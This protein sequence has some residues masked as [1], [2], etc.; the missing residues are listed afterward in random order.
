MLHDCRVDR[1]MTRAQGTLQL[2]TEF[3]D[4]RCHPVMEHI[5]VTSDIQGRVCLRDT[6]MTFGPLERRTEGG[7]VQQVSRGLLLSCYSPRHLDTFVI[8][9]T[10]NFPSH[11]RPISAIPNLVALHSIMKV[12][13][14]LICWP[15]PL[16][17]FL[18]G[19]KLAVTM[20]VGIFALLNRRLDAIVI[21]ALPANYLCSLRSKS[22]CHMQRNDSSRWHTCST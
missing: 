13:L 7:V 9:T 11:L 16:R 15:L 21:A 22:Y 17:V 1:T 8:S 18:Q 14:F 19:S 6:R 4:V 10:P 5:F 12:R 20:L 2:E 3:T